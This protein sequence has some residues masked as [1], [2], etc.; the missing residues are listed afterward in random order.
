MVRRKVGG[1]DW[2]EIILTFGSVTLVGAVWA[3]IAWYIGFQFFA[4]IA[5]ILISLIFAIPVAILLSGRNTGLRFGL[6]LTPEELEP[7]TVLSTLE[8]NLADVNSRHE[9]Q[10]ELE[11]SYGL[12][13]V[14]LDPY[15]NGLHVSL[16]RRRRSTGDSRE[17]L[18]ELANRFLKQGPTALKKTEINAIMND[19]DIVTSLHYRLWSAAETDL[20]AFWRMAMKQYNLSATNPFT[21]LL[22]KKAEA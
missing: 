7:P 11:R 16:L 5:P 6:F 14:C 3:G 9:L 1:V 19:T 8:D 2:R 13:Q 22:A 15:V 4:W 10:P 18:D 21:H 12:V 17:Y 20:A